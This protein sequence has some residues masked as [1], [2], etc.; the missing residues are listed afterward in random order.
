M[1]PITVQEFADSLKEQANLM[2]GDWACAKIHQTDGTVIVVGW[3][4]SEED[5]PE[6]L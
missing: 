3:A 5:I 2:N 4:R 1:K 6:K